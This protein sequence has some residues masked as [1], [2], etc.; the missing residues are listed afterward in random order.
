MKWLYAWPVATALV[1]S[2]ISSR[3]LFVGSAL[4]LIP[5]G[6]LVLS[7]GI[8]AHSKTEATRLGAIYGFS[9]AFVFLWID[10]R[11][12]ISLSQFVILFGIISALGLLA[13]A[14]GALVARVSYWAKISLNH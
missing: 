3:Y 4:S 11:G 14:S 5:W 8:V 12:H 1:M 7:W 6:V 10:K 2:Y 13:A 9:Q